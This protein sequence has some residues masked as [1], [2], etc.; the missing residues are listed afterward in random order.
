MAWTKERFDREGAAIAGSECLY[1]E[2]PL[3]VHARVIETVS[4][5]QGLGFVLES[6]L[7]TGF[8]VSPGQR[9]TIGFGWKYLPVRL[10]LINCAYISLS[11]YFEQELIQDAV[12]FAASL[13][14]LPEP[15]WSSE[16]MFRRYAEIARFMDRRDRARLEA[17]RDSRRCR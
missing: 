4:H 1:R 7:T 14:Q 13:G 3:F 8:A 9:F 5:E 2:R 10:E 17:L 16:T 15:P 6:L 11:L 12:S